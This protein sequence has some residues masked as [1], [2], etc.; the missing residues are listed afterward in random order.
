MWT[1]GAAIAYVTTGLV[2]NIM[3]LRI[4]TV[5]GWAIDAGTFAYPLA[6]TLRDLIHKAGGRGAA[7]LAIVGGAG[8]NIAMVLGIRLAAALPADT[9]IGETAAQTSTYGLMLNNSWR[10]VAA[11]I[12]AQVVAELLDTEAYHRFVVK[13]GP[14]HQWG[15]V[16]AS[17][18]VSI[19]VDSLLFV[20]IAFGW[21]P[22]VVWTNIAFKAL[23]TAVT[24]PLIYL[25]PD[26]SVGSSRHAAVPPG[27][28]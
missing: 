17:N 2:A 18:A 10:I 28:L 8:A 9:S 24:V 22:E 25:V 1:L 23:A 3:S 5:A 27:I 4:V 19:P 20:L 15:R 12:I 7:R 16:A 11:S 14:R 21:Q 6:F 13:W 26:W